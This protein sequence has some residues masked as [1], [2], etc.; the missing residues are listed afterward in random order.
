ML[1][2]HLTCWK[3]GQRQA[4]NRSECRHYLYPVA[5]CLNEFLVVLLKSF[6]SHSLKTI[7]IFMLGYLTMHIRF[8]TYASCLSARLTDLVT[9]RSSTAFPCLLTGNWSRIQREMILLMSGTSTRCQLTCKACSWHFRYA[10]RLCGH[11]GKTS[12]WGVGQL[13]PDVWR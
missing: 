8:D 7:R 13:P 11:E 3:Y 6:I 10:L 4:Q 1:R 9:P 2:G 12:F 5:R